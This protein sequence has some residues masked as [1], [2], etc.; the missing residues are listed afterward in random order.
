MGWVKGVRGA[1][2]AS[3][4]HFGKNF[5]KQKLQG[6]P[7]LAGAGHLFGSQIRISFEIL[8]IWQCLFFIFLRRREILRTR[9]FYQIS[10]VSQKVVL[11]GVAAIAPWFCLRLPSCGPGS[12]P[13]HTIYAFFNLY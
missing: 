6:T 1:S 12:N 11:F 2:G 13:K 9:N 3:T 4:V 5:I 7:D 10:Q 8:C